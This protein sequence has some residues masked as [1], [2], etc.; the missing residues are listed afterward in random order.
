MVCADAFAMCL[1]QQ[2]LD[3][4]GEFSDDTLIETV[5]IICESCAH[6]SAQVERIE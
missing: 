2:Y 4:L 3:A 6:K 5:L 1:A